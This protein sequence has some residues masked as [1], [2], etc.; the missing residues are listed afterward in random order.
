[1]FGRLFYYTN[2]IFYRPSG[3]FF[4]RK[5]QHKLNAIIKLNTLLNC[6]GRGLAPAVILYGTEM[7]ARLSLLCK[8]RWVAER[9]L[10]G[11]LILILYDFVKIPQSFFVLSKNDSSL[12][13]GAYVGQPQGLSLTGCYNF[14]FPI[15]K[16][17]HTFFI[18]LEAEADIVLLAGKTR[19]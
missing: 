1:M 16:V 15:H 6:V 2:F 8:G 11:I 9:Q 10:G 5:S 18:S 13:K 12:Y 14:L 7:F 3:H 17:F 19:I 4:Y